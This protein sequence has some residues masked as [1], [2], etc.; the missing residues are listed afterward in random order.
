MV[1]NIPIKLS[2][3]RKEEPRKF[4]WKS[5]HTYNIIMHYAEDAEA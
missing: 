2:I 5:L 1:S 3:L 4:C